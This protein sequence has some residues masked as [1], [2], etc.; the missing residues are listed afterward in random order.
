[1]ETTRSPLHDELSGTVVHDHS[2]HALNGTIGGDIS[3]GAKGAFSAAARAIQFDGTEG[4][5]ETAAKRAAEFS[6][7]SQPLGRNN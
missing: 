6:A 2:G 7:G 4:W 5:T 3:V 1:V